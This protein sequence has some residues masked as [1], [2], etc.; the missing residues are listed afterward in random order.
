[1]WPEKGIE[2]RK[3]AVT[4]RATPLTSA[5]AKSAKSYRDC[6]TGPFE[7]VAMDAIVLANGIVPK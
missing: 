6:A 5:I 4:A 3:M 7:L 1:M 2:Q